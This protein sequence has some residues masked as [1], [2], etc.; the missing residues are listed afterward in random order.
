M[1][2]RWGQNWPLIVTGLILPGMSFCVQEVGRENS[3]LTISRKSVS[4]GF[5]FSF[6]SGLRGFLLILGFLNDPS[7]NS[8]PFWLIFWFNRYLRQ[9]TSFFFFFFFVLFFNFWLQEL[10]VVLMHALL[11]A[12]Y[13]S[14]KN[15]MELASRLRIKV[16]HSIFCLRFYQSVL[17]LHAQ[18][19]RYSNTQRSKV[20]F[21]LYTTKVAAIRRENTYPFSSWWAFSLSEVCK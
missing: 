10:V 9:C 17:D 19:S 12:T 20:V 16:L 8:A 3:V 7:L 11:G 1:G 21:L 18:F 6:V 14:K 2:G 15:H 13:I 5:A 4:E